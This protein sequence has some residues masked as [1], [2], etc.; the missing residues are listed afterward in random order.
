MG[1]HLAVWPT[2]AALWEENQKLWS[3][4]GAPVLFQPFEDLA[5]PC[6]LPLPILSNSCQCRLSFCRV[7]HRGPVFC[8]HI[9]IRFSSRTKEQKKA[10][11]AWLLDLVKRTRQKILLGLKGSPAAPNPDLNYS[12]LNGHCIYWFFFLNS[13]LIRKNLIVVTLLQVSSEGTAL[14]VDQ[15]WLGIVRLRDYAYRCFA[16]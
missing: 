15:C 14:Q 8:L 1:L 6:Y 3:D 11:L 7:E 2:Q 12:T 4:A 16:I 9:Y 13:E 5:L 10:W